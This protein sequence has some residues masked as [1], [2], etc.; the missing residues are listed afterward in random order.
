MCQIYLFI[1]LFIPFFIN[2]PIDQTRRRIFTLDG[3][4]DADLSKDCLLGFR[5]YFSPFWEW[6]IPKP[7]VYWGVY[8][9]IRRIPTCGVFWQRILT[10][11]IT[12]KQCTFRPFATPLC[13]YPPPFLAIHHCPKPQFWGVNRRFQAKRAKYWKFHVIETT[14]SILTKFGITIETT[15]RSLCVVPVGAQ[16]DGGRPPF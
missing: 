15:K 11:V 8:A 4:N 16:Q 13:I 12:N 9:G 14:V 6:N 1:I 3:S 2:S 5:W 7:V 10:S